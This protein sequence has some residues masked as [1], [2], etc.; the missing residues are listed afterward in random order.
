MGN[1]LT[2]QRY[3]SLLRHFPTGREHL[4]AG[5]TQWVGPQPTTHYSGQYRGARDAV[6]LS[7]PS[8]HLLLLVRSVD[9]FTMGSDGLGR[10]RPE[11]PAFRQDVHLQPNQA[12]GLARRR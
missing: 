3:L 7:G 4:L 11:T 6:Q 1:C 9:F 10:R 2:M 8:R 5:I 12:D